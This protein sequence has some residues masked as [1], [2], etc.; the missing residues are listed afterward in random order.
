MNRL[1]PNVTGKENLNGRKK[2]AIKVAEKNQS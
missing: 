1:R 2:K